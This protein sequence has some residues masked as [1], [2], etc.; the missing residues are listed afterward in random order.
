[1]FSNDAMNDVTRK[2]EGREL[3][4]NRLLEQKI[5][6]KLGLKGQNLGRTEGALLGKNQ[7]G[8]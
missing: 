3:G 1:M 7:G 4:R 2:N 8:Y 5:L 6:E